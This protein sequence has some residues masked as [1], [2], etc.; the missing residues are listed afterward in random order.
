VFRTVPG[1]SDKK[2]RIGAKAFAVLTIALLNPIVRLDK[3]NLA[4][5]ANISERFAT[6]L[7]LGW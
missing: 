3:R 1:I 7:T 4:N 2:R 6:N 5:S